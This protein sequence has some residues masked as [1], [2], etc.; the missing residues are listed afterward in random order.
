MKY[1]P[2]N[3]SL[4]QEIEERNIQCLSSESESRDT[5][6]DEIYNPYYLSLTPG[7]KGRKSTKITLI[8]IV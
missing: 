1:N 2:Y 6:R 5:E 7:L 4:T 3:L 8:I